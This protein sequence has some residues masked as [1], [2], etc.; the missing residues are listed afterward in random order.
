MHKGKTKYMV[1]YDTEEAISIENHQIEKV[2]KYKYL[3]QTLTIDNNIEEE[4]LTRIK[5]GWRNFGIHKDLLTNKDIPM[6]LRKRIF[7][8]CVLTTIVY[9]S[10]TWK[11]HETEQKLV[12][13]E[14]Y[15]KENAAPVI[16]R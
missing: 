2:D 15:G 11:T 7:D 16:K 9:G 6:S 12:T 3:G 14:S 10:E 13:T 8:Q 4:I 1:N 5:A